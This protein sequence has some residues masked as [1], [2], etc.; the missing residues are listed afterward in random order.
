M[1]HAYQW[2][3]LIVLGLAGDPIALTIL[4][5]LGIYALGKKVLGDGNNANNSKN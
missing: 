4:A 1:I 3:K 5:G 2:Q